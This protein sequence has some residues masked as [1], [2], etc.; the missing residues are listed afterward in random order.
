MTGTVGA[1][2]GVRASGLWKSPHSFHNF[3]ILHGRIVGGL[4]TGTASDNRCITE[5]ALNKIGR[6]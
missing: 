1:D 4:L 6:R 2:G 3:T 5:L